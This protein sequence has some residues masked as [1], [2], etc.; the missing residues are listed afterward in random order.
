[1]I[2][3]A[4]TIFRCKIVKFWVQ[5]GRFWVQTEQNNGSTFA[6]VKQIFEFTGRLT[7]ITEIRPFLVQNNPH[8]TRKLIFEEEGYFPQKLAGDIF[9]ERCEQLFYEGEKY[10]IK[11]EINLRVNQQL[12][13]NNIKIVEIRKIDNE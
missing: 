9:D 3:P 8:F 7:Q 5:N 12:Y 2:R 4:K 11:F 6:N 1:M 13:F 10:H